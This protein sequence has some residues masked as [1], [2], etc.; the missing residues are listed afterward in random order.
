MNEIET[1]W[2]RFANDFEQRNTYVIGKSDINL[3][4]KNVESLPPMDNVLELACGDGVYSKIL[5]KNSKRLLA[6]DFSE[7][8]V[9]ASKERLKSF[10]NVTVEKANCFD[11]QYSDKSFDTV[12]MANL[13][14]IIPTPEK[15][16]EECKRVLKPG[17]NLIVVS[18][19][20]KE[21]KFI[22]KIGM[23]FRYLRTYGKPAQAGKNYSL[24]EAC[25]LILSTG[26]KVEKSELLGEKSKAFMVLS[27]KQLG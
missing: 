16:L 11:L 10:N 5:A 17:G 2:S 1:Y 23:G 7:E 3:I 22:H 24:S 9:K 13:I 15:A 18:Y 21:M 19:T 8:M 26:F 14:H 12:F 27:V 25:D 20:L 4:F 6:T